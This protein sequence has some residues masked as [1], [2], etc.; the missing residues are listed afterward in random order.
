LAAE[1]KDVPSS[2]LHSEDKM[3]KALTKGG[4]FA[5]IAYP[6]PMVEHKAARQLAIAELKKQS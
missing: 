4:Q 6:V 3:R 1:L 2:I 5:D